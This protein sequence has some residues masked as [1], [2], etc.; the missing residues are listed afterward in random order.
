MKYN[1]CFVSFIWFFSSNFDDGFKIISRGE[2]YSIN[3][4]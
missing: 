4:I 2:Y 3:K 1:N